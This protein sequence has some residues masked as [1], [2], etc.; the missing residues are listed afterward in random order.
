[1]TWRIRR[2][3]WCMGL[4]EIPFSQ[5][6]RN[7]AH[8]QQPRKHPHLTVIKMQ[9]PEAPVLGRIDWRKAGETKGIGEERIDWRK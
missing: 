2:D 6:K 3:S 7:P 9:S 4:G 5:G 1:M 8:G